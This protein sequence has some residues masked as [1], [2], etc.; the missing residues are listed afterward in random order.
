MTNQDSLEAD[1]LEAFIVAL[2]ANSGL[3]VDCVPYIRRASPSE[4]AK[5]AKFVAALM[6]GTPPSKLN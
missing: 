3:P 5:S 2:F 1:R 6:L 4:I